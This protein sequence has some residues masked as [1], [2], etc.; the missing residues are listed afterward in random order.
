MPETA[1]KSCFFGCFCL[2]SN[3]SFSATF[4]PIDLIGSALESS[5]II[6]CI[7]ATY[8][9]L[10]AFPEQARALLCGESE[11]LIKN[12]NFVSITYVPGDAREMLAN[13]H[14]VQ[15]MGQ[16]FFNAQLFMHFEQKLIEISKI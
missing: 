12:L 3:A 1:K 9:H 14:K 4:C 6:L 13:A 7:F 8:E 2:T 11:N 10:R 16:E 15:S 5:C